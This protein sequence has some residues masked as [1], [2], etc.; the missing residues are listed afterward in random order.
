[1]QCKKRL[2]PQLGSSCFVVRMGQGCWV[3]GNDLSASLPGS[4][5]TDER[6]WPVWSGGRAFSVRKYVAEQ[7][8]RKQVRFVLPWS[9][10]LKRKDQIDTV[11]F[12]MGGHKRFRILV[13]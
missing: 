5:G 6:L 9:A 2:F 4:A 12:G 11:S 8:W 7:D 13:S 3:M 10:A 1:M